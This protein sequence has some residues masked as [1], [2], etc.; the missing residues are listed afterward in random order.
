MLRFFFPQDGGE[1]GGQFC[2]YT[3]TE[4]EQTDRDTETRQ[5]QAGGDDQGPRLPA[6]RFI[7][8][9]VVIV[10]TLLTSYR[11]AAESHFNDW[12]H[13]QVARHTTMALAWVG[14]S[15]ALEG[16]ERG[17]L[18][19][20]EVRANLAAWKRGAEAPAAEDLAQASGA[21]LTA[22][23]RWSYRAQRAHRSKV[24]G[25]TGPR[26]SFVL[27][28]GVN[29][30][31]VQAETELSA[32]RNSAVLGEAEKASEI[33]RLTGRIATLREE[34]A[35]NQET[36]GQQRKNRGYAF[37]FIIIP[38]CGAIE[39]MSIF[40]AAV[41]AFPTL[42][43][44]RLAGLAV[45][46]PAMYL[47]NIFR[48]TCLAV[49]GALD[50]G[51]KWFQFS[52]YY[53]WQAVYIV[54]VVAVWLVWVEFM[55]RE[56][57]P[58]E[59]VLGSVVTALWRLRM[60]RIWRVAFFCL[61]FL[62]IV[63]VLVVAWWSLLPVYGYFLLQASGAILRHV[64]G[65]PI[66]AGWIETGGVLNT[67]SWMY[68]RIEGV[69]DK[70]TA[71][72]LLITNLPPYLALVL[73]TPGLRWVRRLLILIY[74]CAIL[75]AGHILFLVVVLRFQEALR[76]YSELPTAVMQFYL[77]LPFLLWIVFAYWQR[78]LGARNGSFSKPHEESSHDQT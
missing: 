66:L 42:W 65:V 43:R 47:V 24:R 67:D 58:G 7:V 57:A 29:D 55:V 13:F 37:P 3:M 63:V 10:M 19:P 5:A 75:V 17:S 61:K 4:A 44:R 50:S 8:A 1:T 54:F 14:H 48:L 76:E 9:F 78:L 56:R 2:G 64:M 35:R 25:S 31:I 16:D 59:T 34:Q 15:S 53:V 21:P 6:L 40:L 23:E 39:V 45:G 62:V 70:K 69:N 30:R 11:Y 28:L 72:A 60:G 33:E 77:T 18:N 22:W 73:A 68:F 26:V 36:P 51:G 52:H 71:L 46:I 74:G 32:V 20:E 12:Y 41:L 49:I 27:S 38:E